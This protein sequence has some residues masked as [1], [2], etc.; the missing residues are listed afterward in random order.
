M[1]A[2]SGAGRGSIR[3]SPSSSSSS[4]HSRLL[5]WLVV[6]GSHLS[7]PRRMR[8]DGPME[9]RHRGTDGPRPRPAEGISTRQQTRRAGGRGSGP[10]QGRGA[11]GG[12]GRHE[13]TLRTPRL[14]LVAPR[15]GRDR[16]MAPLYLHA[17]K[18]DPFTQRWASGEGA[19]S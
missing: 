2:R 6:A 9:H 1:E 19:D 3:S 13:L 5:R 11:I 16:L 18:A 4:C 15:L 17:M 14:R 8:E 7:F 12:Q 10:K